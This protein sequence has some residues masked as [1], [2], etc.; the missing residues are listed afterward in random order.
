VVYRVQRFDLNR[1]IGGTVQNGHAKMMIGVM[2]DQ[3][4]GQGHR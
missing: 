3:S 1:M 4:G 2:F